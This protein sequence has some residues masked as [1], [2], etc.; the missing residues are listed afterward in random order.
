MQMAPSS[1]RREDSGWD[2]RKPLLQGH[3]H[4]GG[5][6]ASLNHSHST[7]LTTSSIAP[8]LT[9]TT[10]GAGAVT[11]SPL[12]VRNRLPEVGRFAQSHRARPQIQGSSQ[13]A[14]MEEPYRS[15]CCPMQHQVH[16]Q[17]LNKYV[18]NRQAEPHLE[19]NKEKDATFIK[20]RRKQSSHIMREVF[21]GMQAGKDLG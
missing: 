5:I 6:S 11:I 7:V 10:H 8:H 18:T 2:E 16:Q 19:R 4:R 13:R 17:A 12:Q 14:R 1:R 20:Y 15:G 3:P 21:V 9:A